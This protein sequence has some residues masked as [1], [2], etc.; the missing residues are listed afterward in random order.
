MLGLF[1]VW[2]Y[3]WVSAPSRARTLIGLLVLAL[4]WLLML[5]GRGV[6][7]IEHLAIPTALGLLLTLAWWFRKGS[8][9]AASPAQRGRAR[10]EGADRG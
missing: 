2:M 7:A 3:L 6:L 1:P 9:P 4:P 8:L 10:L 5:G